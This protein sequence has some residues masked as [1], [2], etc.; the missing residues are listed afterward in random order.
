[1]NRPF[2]PLETLDISCLGGLRFV[3]AASGRAIVDGLGVSVRRKDI[4]RTLPASPSGTF[5]LHGFPGFKATERWDGQGDPPAPPEPFD[6]TVVDTSGEYLSMRFPSQLPV[7]REAGFWRPAPDAGILPVPLYSAPA[8]RG[9]AGFQRLRGWLVDRDTKAPAAWARIRVTTAQAVAAERQVLGE[10]MSDGN[11]SFMVPY[12]MPAAE[13]APAPAPG[14][15]PPAR[16]RILVEAGRSSAAPL[17]FPDLSQVLAQPAVTL[18]KKL[19]AEAL[20]AQDIT[21]G[22]ELILKTLETVDHHDVARSEL[23]FATH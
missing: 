21:P 19:P 4:V 16:Y 6:V 2:E 17:E 22:L 9:P 12:R 23:F 1:M 10:S 3:D 15:P 5:V 11:G 7:P 13:P 14:V 8:R 18:L 20:A